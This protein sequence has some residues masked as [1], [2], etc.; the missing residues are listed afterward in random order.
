MERETKRERERGAFSAAVQFFENTSIHLSLFP[1]CAYIYIY[2]YIYIYFA[3]IPPPLPRILI[4]R[5][6]GYSRATTRAYKSHPGEI[7]SI[8]AFE[9]SYLPLFLS[10]SVAQLLNLL[11]AVRLSHRNRDINPSFHP[12][13]RIPPL[14]RRTRATFKPV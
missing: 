6:S 10:F 12:I 4:L 14:V 13:G 2:I 9:S 3:T 1:R 5:S 11:V 7:C 8:R